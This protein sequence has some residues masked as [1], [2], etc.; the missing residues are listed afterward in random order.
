MTTREPVAQRPSRSR[1]VA[2]VAETPVGAPRWA[3]PVTLTLVLLGVAVASYLTYA[4]FTSP[5]VLACSDKG[6]INCAKVTTSAQSVF[7]GVPVAVL[8]LGYF[9]AVAPLMLPA[10][11]RSS[12]RRLRW[13]R[14]AA[15][16]AGLGFVFWLLYAE[17]FILDA[18]CLWCSVVHV[19]TLLLFTATAL[20]AALTLDD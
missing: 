12:D 15:V 14:L 1:P 13:G 17:L 8:G 2:E 16:T 20:A 11:W 7:L 10:A 9:L 5:E 3:A 19:L 18:I 6:T 4:H